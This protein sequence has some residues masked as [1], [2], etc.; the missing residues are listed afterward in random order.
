MW[1]VGR[2]K[3]KGKEK[4]KTQ[5]ERRKVMEEGSVKAGEENR[6]YRGGCWRGLDR[7]RTA[8]GGHRRS[9][10][11]PGAWG[12]EGPQGAWESGDT[13]RHTRSKARKRSREGNRLLTLPLSGAVLCICLPSSVCTLS[14]ISKKVSPRH[15]HRSRR[16]GVPC[17]HK[18]IK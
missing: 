11:T 2:G 9:P 18:S 1:G 17:A 4:L 10:Q 13:A 6:K 7:G 8:G 15:E 16:Q 5:R 12:A 3:A 14:T